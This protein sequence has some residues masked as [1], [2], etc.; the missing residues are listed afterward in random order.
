[1]SKLFT[2]A[3]GPRQLSHSRDRFPRDSW[4]YFTASD[5]RL[6]QPGGPGPSGTAWP[7]YTPRHRVIYTTSE[8][9]IRRLYSTGRTMFSFILHCSGLLQSSSVLQLHLN[10]HFFPIVSALPKVIP[11]Q[12]VVTFRI[13]S[14]A[15]KCDPVWWFFLVGKEK[16]V[17]QSEIW[18]ISGAQG[19][20]KTPWRKVLCVRA[21]CRRTLLALTMNPLPNTFQNLLTYL[22]N[23][24]CTLRCR[25]FAESPPCS[26]VFRQLLGFEP[27]PRQFVVLLSCPACNPASFECV[28]DWPSAF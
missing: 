7:G 16:E 1:M 23:S 28:G 9:E 4:P 5:S 25:G 19:A 8:S 6:P 3:A 14:V 26:P 24:S 27:Y 17:A 12:T 22:I 18:W 20:L 13:T 2:V 21:R 11:L 10:F 15:P